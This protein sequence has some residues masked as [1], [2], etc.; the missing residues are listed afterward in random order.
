[1]YLTAEHPDPAH[2]ERARQVAIGILP[3]IEALALFIAN[4]V[5]LVVA[6]IGSRLIP[7]APPT[8]R[9]MPLPGSRFQNTPVPGKPVEPMVA[10]AT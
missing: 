7:A 5:V 8:N 3:G 6:M 1:M 9:R 4:V 10:V 2:P